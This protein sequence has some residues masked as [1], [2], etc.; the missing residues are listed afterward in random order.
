MLQKN[1]TRNIMLDSGFRQLG[2]SGNFVFSVTDNGLTDVKI[3][4]QR[5]Y[6]LMW[7][8]NYKVTKY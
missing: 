4:S 6:F 1:G 8:L 5:S 3:Y 7:K 2:K